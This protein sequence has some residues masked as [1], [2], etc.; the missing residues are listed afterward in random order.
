MIFPIPMVC[1]H[2][3]Y[4]ICGFSHFQTHQPSFRSTFSGLPELALGHWKE[5][6]RKGPQKRR[7]AIFRMNPNHVSG[8]ETQEKDRLCWKYHPISGKFWRKH[9]LVHILEIRVYLFL[10]YYGPIFI[11]MFAT[12]PVANKKCLWVSSWNESGSG[13]GCKWA[14]LKIRMKLCQSGWSPAIGELSFRRHGCGQRVWL[15]GQTWQRCGA[16]SLGIWSL[17]ARTEVELMEVIEVIYPWKSTQPH[18]QVLNTSQ[19]IV[20]CQLHTYRSR[21][22]VQKDPQIDWL[23]FYKLANLG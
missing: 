23:F 14:G 20:G 5:V 17:A 12:S 8:K 22:L 2:F 15:E 16:A 3:P 21:F 19:I 4:E 1:P 6:P 7:L 13:A 18:P 10:R 9:H 11:Q